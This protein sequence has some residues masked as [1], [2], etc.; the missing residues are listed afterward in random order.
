MNEQTVE[1]EGNGLKK[2]MGPAYLFTM[3]V[4]TIIGPWLVM[5]N[6]WLSLTGPSIFLSFV[7][8]G[9]M[10]IPIGLVYGELTA[11]LPQVGGSLLFHQ[12]GIRK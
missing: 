11:M 12:K 6:W 4:A 9:L 5:T 10:C 3:A 7:I 8:V 2:T 1:G